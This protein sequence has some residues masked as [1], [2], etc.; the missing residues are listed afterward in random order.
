MNQQWQMRMQSS[1]LASVAL[2]AVILAAIVSAFLPD[3]S[4][5]DRTTR[6]YLPQLISQLR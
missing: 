1:S 6:A 5:S 2:M 3:K 4:H